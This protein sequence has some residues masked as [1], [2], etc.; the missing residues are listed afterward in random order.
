[1]IA[2]ELLP[3]IARMLFTLQVCI[4]HMW[5]HLENRGG[6]I[7]PNIANVDANVGINIDLHLNL[8]SDWNL[9]FESVYV[10]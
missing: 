6:R 10:D 7:D 1:M 9:D 4:N 5:T 3:R 2:D 8:Y